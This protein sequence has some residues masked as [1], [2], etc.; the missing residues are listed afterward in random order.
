MAK[1]RKYIKRTV[2]T[3]RIKRGGRKDENYNPIALT[4][5][6]G[7]QSGAGQSGGNP[8]PSPA[9]GSG[10]NIYTID[11][12]SLRDS[13]QSFGDAVYAFKET[14]ITD[15][16]TFEVPE[17]IPT[18]PVTAGSLYALLLAQKSSADNLLTSANSVYDAFYNTRVVGSAP[19]N[20]I[21]GGGIYRAIYGNSAIFVPT[22]TS[23]APAPRAVSGGSVGGVVPAA[24]S[25]SV[26]NITST[27]NLL[28][29]LQAF[30]D[31]L[32]GFKSAAQAQV[33]QAASPSLTS[34]QPTATTGPA[35]AAF[36]AQQTAANDL[37]TAAN[38][39]LTAFAGNPSTMFPDSDGGTGPYDGVNGTR[40]LYRAIIS[41]S[42]NFVPTPP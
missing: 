31:K 1:S 39:V 5:M 22:P 21:P 29:A 10:L 36:I 20:S 41:N 4:Q 2:K 35:Y 17:G 7:G 16:E 12:V 32:I 38:S 9:P 18:T 23:P 28:A 30:G 34:F 6:Q 37:V 25:G 42:A 40:G 27:A 13:L 14:A 24:A 8:S 26:L 33:T 19:V 3:K 15:V 11:T